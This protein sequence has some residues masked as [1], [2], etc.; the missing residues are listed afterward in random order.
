M[1]TKRSILSMTAALALAV[2]SIPATAD[3]GGEGRYHGPNAL[4]GSWRVTITPYNCVTLAEFPQFA[5]ES[6]LTFNRGGTLL[7]TT[8]SANF[9]P[10]Q[11][12]AGHGYWER[13]GPNF[14]HA[15]FEAFVQ[16]T[17][18]EA[19]PPPTPYYQRGRQ[20]LTQGIEMVDLDHWE[21]L[22]KV[23]FFDF[24]GTPTRPLGCAK[25]EGTRIN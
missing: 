12:S 2:L 3:R 11:R 18:K 8:S 5:F 1:T 21:S 4:V 17:L 25:A 6:L 20:V 9:A 15:V 10:G 13:S 14:Y 19:P 16:F 7:E 22:A 24:A 23:E